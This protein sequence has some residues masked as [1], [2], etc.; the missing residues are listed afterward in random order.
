MSVRLLEQLDLIADAPNGIQKL[1]GLILELAVRGKLVSVDTE[2]SA[3]ITLGEVGK[4]AVGSGF[5]TAEQGKLGLEIL[6]AKVSDMN[7]PENKR[8]I[9]VTN[10]TIS[11]ESAKRLKVNI[12]PTGTVVF[13]K[14]GGAIA[15]NKR[16]VLVQDTAID[17]N[18]LGITPK[19]GIDSDWLFV[20]LSSIDLTKYQAGTSV[21]ALAQGILSEIPVLLPPLAEQ[22][23]IVAKVDELMALCDRMEAERADAES[24]HNT[25]V[26]TLLAT[27]TQ[28]A[29]AAELAASH[30]PCLALLTSSTIMF[31]HCL[32]MEETWWDVWR[33]CCLAQ[34]R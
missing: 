16:R 18:C 31:L 5:P 11:R 29:D 33:W 24:A 34:R 14:I 10:H 26:H 2:L 19:T 20:L 30:S 3:T 21:P 4:W 25:L 8:F 9:S 23:R 27:L 13:P 22:N 6:F 1:R 28:S 17:N 12:H 32:V 15:T 7:L